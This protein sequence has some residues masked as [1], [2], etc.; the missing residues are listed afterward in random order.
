MKSII[1]VVIGL[2]S[3]VY[4]KAAVADPT[5]TVFIQTNAFQS[6]PG[7]IRVIKKL[8]SLF[9]T[10]ESMEYQ[11]MLSMN[12]IKEL[13]LKEKLQLRILDTYYYD[14]YYIMYRAEK[15]W[16]IVDLKVEADTVKM[17]TLRRENAEGYDSDNIID[18]IMV[19]FWIVLIDTFIAFLYLF[20]VSL[21]PTKKFI[22]E[23][24]MWYS[25]F[26][27][28]YCILAYL[29]VPELSLSLSPLP[30]AFI[31]LSI[32][33]LLLPWGLKH[34]RKEDKRRAENEAKEKEVVESE[35]SQ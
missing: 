31:M 28:I 27:T 33:A 17:A 20:I 4:Y 22:I 19:N 32:Y 23:S 10:R 29:I 26:C 6:Q 15:Y 16:K 13:W 18:S 5:D 24:F 25:I 35:P 34:K 9:F 30:W 12:Q 1:I 8:D 3:L 2:L 21:L 14:D 7:N 11:P